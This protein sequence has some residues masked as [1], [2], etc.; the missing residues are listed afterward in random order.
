MILAAS[1]AHTSLALGED[2]EDLLNEVRRTTGYHQNGISVFTRQLGLSDSKKHLVFSTD[3]GTIGVV[4][5]SDNQVTRMK[6]SHTTVCAPTCSPVL[7][8]QTPC[9]T[10]RYARRSSSYPT[11]Q[12]SWLAAVTT[13]P[14]F[15]STSNLEMYCPVMISVNAF[16]S[17]GMLVY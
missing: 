7:E 14:S 1:D 8:G 3:A 15:T 16:H 12:V 2:E 6:T 5:L 10:S 13:L 11:G 9:F 4:D 17:I